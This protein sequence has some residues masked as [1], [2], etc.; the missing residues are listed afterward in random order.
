[1]VRR[2]CCLAIL[3]LIC[4]PGMFAQVQCPSNANAGQPTSPD[5]ANFPVDSNVTFTWAASTVSSVT[6]DIVAWQNIN[7]PQT[8]CANQTSTTCTFTFTATGQWSWAVKTKKATCTD[9]PSGAKTFTIGC[10]SNPPSLQSPS[11]GSTNVSQN[12]TFTWS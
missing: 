1:M 2:L 3:F 9:I 12:P 11:E 7:S 10:L 4:A 6:Y 5:G 8:V